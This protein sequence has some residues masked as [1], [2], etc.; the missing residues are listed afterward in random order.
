MSYKKVLEK[1]KKKREREGVI[2]C[3]GKIKHRCVFIAHLM[4]RKLALGIK[5]KKKK[6][7]NPRCSIDLWRSKCPEETSFFSFL[8]FLSDLEVK[9]GTTKMYGVRSFCSFLFF[10]LAFGVT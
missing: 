6:A 3:V 1:L 7:I 8:N 10:F 5:K 9:K 2:R 4:E